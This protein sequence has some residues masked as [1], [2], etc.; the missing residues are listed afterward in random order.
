MILGN[1]VISIIYIIVGPSA[2]TDDFGVVVTD[3]GVIVFFLGTVTFSEGGNGALS[4]AFN[5][6][7]IIQIF[8]IVGLLV[9]A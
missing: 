4:N 9:I 2:S 5:T 1:R 6:G 8:P 7:G 3:T